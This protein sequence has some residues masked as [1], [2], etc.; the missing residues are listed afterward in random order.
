MLKVRKVEPRD[1]ELL[2]RA[3]EADPFHARA[4]LTGEHWSD[5]LFYEDDTGPVVALK[6]TTV[7]RV[8]IQFLSHDRVR[9][10]R[11][12]LDGFSSYIEVIQKRGI[13]EVIFSTDSAAVVRFMEKRFKFRHLG[14]REYSLRIA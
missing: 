11:A 3:A 2:N 7:A 6:T 9:N 5:G 12:L 14:G 4:G 1:Q 10:S 13:K 8:D